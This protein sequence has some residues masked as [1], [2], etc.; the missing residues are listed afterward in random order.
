MAAASSGSATSMQARACFVPASIPGLAPADPLSRAAHGSRKR[1]RKPFAP[2]SAPAAPA[3][4][5]TSAPT[6]MPAAS[7]I[8]IGSTT[9]RGSPAGAAARPSAESCRGSARPSSARAARGK[10]A[11]RFLLEALAHQRMDEL[12]HVA[13]ERGDLA[14]ERRRDEHVLLG[15]REE[16]GLHL[17]VEMTV[18]AGELE[19]VLEIRNG[20]QPPQHDP[21]SL[22]A[23][24]IDEQAAE[25][26][27]LHVLYVG[28]HFARHRDALIDREE[29]A[30]R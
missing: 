29:R 10:S 11:L 18:H 9:A 21:R 8:A 3:C 7:R 25:A 2:R 17:R 15:G 13:A 16:K 26:E 30:L 22:L 23:H 20:A 12:G 5:T 27:H 1:S 4:A 14:H 24:E 28:E 6:A 19:L